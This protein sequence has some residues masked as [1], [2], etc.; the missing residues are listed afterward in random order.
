MSKRFI[1]VAAGL[2]LTHDGQL[3]LA[4]RPG[5]KPWSGWW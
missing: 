2:L 3:L 4:Q 1:D 5:D